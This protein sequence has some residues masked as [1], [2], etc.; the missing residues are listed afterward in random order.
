MNM[1][2]TQKMRHAGA[3]HKSE[4]PSWVTRFAEKLQSPERSSRREKVAR[5]L[6]MLATIGATLTVATGISVYRDSGSIEPVGNLL[7]PVAEHVLTTDEDIATADG[8]SNIIALED[9][10][11]EETRMHYVARGT[12]ALAL[13]SITLCLLNEQAHRSSRKKA[14]P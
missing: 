8:L 3:R 11:A 2:T 10:R 12:E 9:R 5:A 1:T 13:S 7:N 6:G 4:K 14:Q